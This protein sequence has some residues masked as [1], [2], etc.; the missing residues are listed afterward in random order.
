ME[1]LSLNEVYKTLGAV[2]VYLEK[3]EERVA[4]DSQFLYNLLSVVVDN[5]DLIFGEN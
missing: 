3:G 4:I 2:N 5:E 1:E